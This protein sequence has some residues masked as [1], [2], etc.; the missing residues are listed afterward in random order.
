MAF[1]SVRYEDLR[2]TRGRPSIFASS[3]IAERAF[4]SACG[5]PLTYHRVKSGSIGVTIGSLDVPE[6]AH[7]VQQYAIE[8]Q[9]SWIAA[10]R[11]L[12]A[13]RIEHWMRENGI[14]DIDS[15][16]YSA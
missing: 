5:T 16:Q 14:A 10:L 9:L 2:W 15:R 12:P 3:N 11:A 1:A 8:S 13:K 4:C 7:P 6:A